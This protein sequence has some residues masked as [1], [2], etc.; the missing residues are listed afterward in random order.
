M[1]GRAFLSAAVVFM[2][3][4]MTG[5]VQNA[6]GQCQAHE[7]QRL[8]ASDAA[9]GDEYGWSVSMT[10]GWAVIGRCVSGPARPLS[11]TRLA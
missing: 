9:G 10:P 5:P 7:L 6:Q 3:I 11:G 4:A 1:T 8:T 2:L